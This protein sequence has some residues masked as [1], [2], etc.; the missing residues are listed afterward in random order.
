MNTQDKDA[1]ELAATNHANE[2]CNKEEDKE[3]W[4][5]CFNDFKKGATWQS[6]TNQPS[7][8]ESDLDK[9]FDEQTKGVDFGCMLSYEYETSEVKDIAREYFKDGYKAANKEQSFTL[10]DVEDAF[11]AGEIT[12]ANNI[13]IDRETGELKYNSEKAD[14]DKEQY[15]AQLLKEKK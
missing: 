1:L 13:N 12:S 4:I 11:E 5:M 9:L 15:I 14:K 3:G 8:I 10:K 2:W 7:T 6:S